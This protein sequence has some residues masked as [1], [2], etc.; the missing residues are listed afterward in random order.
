MNK[1]IVKMWSLINDELLAFKIY[2]M[3]IELKLD[4]FVDKMQKPR[5]SIFLIRKDIT[6]DS[7]PHD[8]SSKPW[9]YS[10]RKVYEHETTKP[11]IDLMKAYC[12]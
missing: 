8:T 3:D 7:S 2:V 9:E 11:I 10:D 12:M 5:R 1:T 4:I 6:P